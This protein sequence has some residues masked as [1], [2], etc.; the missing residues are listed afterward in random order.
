[1]HSRFF[2]FFIIA[3]FFTVS[4]LAS[5]LSPLQKILPKI[6]TGKG[7]SFK[8]YGPTSFEEKTLEGAVT[9]YGPASFKDVTVNAS[10]HVMGP[11][12]A[13][14]SFFQTIHVDGPLSL[15]MCEIKNGLV[16]GPVEMTSCKVNEMIEINGSLF[17]S[18]SEFNGDIS[19][20]TNELT[21]QG[22]TKAKNIFIRATQ[23]DKEQK[24]YLKDRALVEGDIA[25]EAGKGKV[26]VSEG[27]KVAGQISGGT[28]VK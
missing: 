24:V 22:Q 23:E 8:S 18:T 9:V 26:F 13:E 6:V 27:A 28:L 1:M 14:K 25:F 16:N 15:K 19:I 2:Y 11:M 21:L 12:V 5:S 3:G 7:S 4:S 10:T 20:A 17:S